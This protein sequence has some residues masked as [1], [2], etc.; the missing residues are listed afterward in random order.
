[1]QELA[2]VHFA[3]GPL[4]RVRA[5]EEDRRT[6]RRLRAESGGFTQRVFQLV[7]APL[8]VRA[9]QFAGRVDLT[10][11]LLARKDD[12]VALTRAIDLELLFRV[13]HRAGQSFAPADDVKLPVAQRDDLRRAIL[14]YVLALRREIGTG[15]VGFDE[16]V[17]R[18]AGVERQREG[19]S[20]S[21]RGK[22]AGKHGAPS[23]GGRARGVKARV[24][25]AGQPLRSLLADWSC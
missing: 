11:P 4:V 1:M 3:A 15:L 19:E 24:R 10:L 6:R 25:R 17:V 14:A 2:I 12:L 16:R 7:R 21:E 23:V 9:A 8:L 22:S 5:V 18:R 20:K 13:R